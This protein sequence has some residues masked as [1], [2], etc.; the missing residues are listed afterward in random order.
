[1]NPYT[2]TYAVIGLF[3]LW[4]CGELDPSHPLDPD[5]PVQQQMPAKLMGQVITPTGFDVRAVQDVTVHI[6]PISEGLVSRR[7]EVAENGQFNLDDVVPGSYRLTA[8][9]PGLTGGPV[10][11]DARFGSELDVGAIPLTPVLGQVKGWVFQTNGQPATGAVVSS[12]DGYEVTVVD[13]EGRFTIRVLEGQRSVNVVLSKHSPWTSAEL[14]VQAWDALD[15]EQPI[16]LDPYPG[17]LV[18]QVQLRQFSTPQ[19]ARQIRMEL[20]PVEEPAADDGESSEGSLFR[21][22][23]VTRSDFS[24]ARETGTFELLDVEAGKYHLKLRAEGYDEQSWPVVVRAD[25]TTNLGRLELNHTSTGSLAVP[26]SGRVHT[27]GVGLVAVGLTA[28]IV[29][30]GTES[31]LMFER[32]V[33]DSNGEFSFHASPEEWY[34][35][36]AQVTGFAEIDAGPYRY[37]PGQGFRDPAGRAPDFNL[38]AAGP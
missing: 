8:W 5:T 22:T 20:E 17:H 3:M 12:D 34:A 38:G 9:G 6:D 2:S 24:P 25:E 11:V 29:S 15:M 19:R 31:D 33:T 36:R 35:I 14:E 26:F 23:R 37:F 21:D 16:F 13:T 7:A 28:S 30:R 27:G 1:M 18:G 10:V 4:S 32:L